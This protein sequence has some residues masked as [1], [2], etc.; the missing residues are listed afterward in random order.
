M[1]DIDKCQNASLCWDALRQLSVFLSKPAELS[2]NSILNQSPI[3]ATNSARRYNISNVAAQL[4]T[5]YAIFIEFNFG[6]CF[7]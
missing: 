2:I 6:T 4:L 5:N 7:Q 3:K 1:Y